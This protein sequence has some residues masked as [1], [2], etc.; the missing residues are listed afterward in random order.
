MLKA[1]GWLVTVSAVMLGFVLLGQ[2]SQKSASIYESNVGAICAVSPYFS[3]VVTLEIAGRKFR[4]TLPF[5]SKYGHGTGVFIS[6]GKYVITAAHV[7]N[8]APLVK[9]STADGRV[10]RASV[11]FLDQKNDLA[12]LKVLRTDWFVVAPETSQEYTIGEEV[13]AIG[14]P[15]RFKYI[16]THGI[17]S[18]LDEGRLVSDAPVN[19]GSSGGP[20][21][22]LAGEIVG[23]THAIYAGER[24]YNPMSIFISVTEVNKFLEGLQL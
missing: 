16:I 12:L 15:L 19:F 22:N 21:F 10:A 3:P 4:I 1:T 13:F 14:N 18:G 5:S 20:L 9:L 24:I 2:K 7:A 8:M 6:N 11:L 17:I 23:I